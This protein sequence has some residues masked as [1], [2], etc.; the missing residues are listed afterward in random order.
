MVLAFQFGTNWAEFSRF[1][2]VIFAAPLALEIFF[3]FFLESVF[4]GVII[5]RW[6][7]KRV[8][9]KI[10]WISTIFVALGTTLSAFWILVANSWMQSPRGFAHSADGQ[11]WV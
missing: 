8:S 2:A 3:A 4:L 11:K 10:L 5:Q 6:K 7:S 1:V 9:D